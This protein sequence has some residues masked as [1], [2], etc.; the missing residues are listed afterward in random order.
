[1]ISLRKVAAVTLAASVLLSMAA[2]GKK[3]EGSHSGQKISA[4]M[5]WYD[6]TAYDVDQG[7]DPEKKVQNGYSQMCGFDDDCIVILTQGNYERPADFNWKEDDYTAYQISTMSILDR[8][9]KST[10]KTINLYEL[11]SSSDYVESA[12]YVNGKICLTVSGFDT[13]T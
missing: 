10:I 13:E 9:T 1:M 4:N 11:F 3:K 12:S 8:K 5:P 6:V 2:C 7:L